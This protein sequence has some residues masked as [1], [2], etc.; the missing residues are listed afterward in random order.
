[1]LR[2]PSS[3]NSFPALIRSPF[4]SFQSQGSLQEIIAMSCWDWQATLLQPPLAGMKNKLLRGDFILT[5]ANA[6]AVTQWD[7]GS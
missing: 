3:L 6:T 1:M 2:F 4:P 7:K 5:L